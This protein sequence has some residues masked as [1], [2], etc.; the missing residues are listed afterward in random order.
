MS[1]LNSDDI[2]LPGALNAVG[3]TFARYPD[4]LWLTG[5]SANTDVDDHVQLSRLPTGHLRGLI[6]RGWYHGRAL[7]FIRQEGTFWRRELWQR[8]GSQVNVN[9]RYA[10]DFDLWQRFAAQTDL[11]S[12]DKHLAAF[13]FQPEQKTAAIEHYYA[14]AGVRLPPAARLVALPLRAMFT[15]ASWPLAPRVLWKGDT[16]HFMPG[17]RVTRKR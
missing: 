17:V 8:V 6:R 1:W 5:Q 2:L 7:G 10:M 11:V 12:M 13:R 16:P 4:I 15:W 9:K 14:E 3:E